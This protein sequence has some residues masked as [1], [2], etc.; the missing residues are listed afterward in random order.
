MADRHR[1]FWLLVFG[2]GVALRLALWSGYGL[3]DDPNYFT[4]YYS[5]YTRGGTFDPHD[6][7]QMR[8]GLWVPV[9]LA[10]RLFGPTEAGFVG[11][12]TICS[13]INLVLIYLLARQEWER[14]Y[15]LL[16]MLLLAVCPL[17]VLCSGLFANDI[18]LATYCFAAL[19]LFRRSLRDEMSPRARFASAAASGMFLF[20]GF[21][22]KPWVILTAPLF[23]IEA[24]ARARRHWR[25]SLVAVGVLAT[26]VGTFLA[27]QW[28]RFGDPLYHVNVARPFAI[29]EPYSRPVLL[30]YPRMLFD[31]NEYGSYFAGYYPHVLVL[32]AALLAGRFFRAGKWLVYAAIMLAGLVALPGGRQNGLWGVIPHIFRYLALL[33]VPLCMALTA[34]WRELFGRR[35]EAAVVWLPAFVILSL[36]QCVA[37]TEPTRDAYGEQRRA[38]AFLRNYPDDPVWMDVSLGGRFVYFELRFTKFERLRSIRGEH[39]EERAREYA[40]ITDGMVVTGGARNPW[41]NCFPCLGYLDHFSVPPTWS[42]EATFPGRPT[43]YR[44]EPLRIWRVS[45]DAVKAKALLDERP[46]WSA[47]RELLTGLLDRGENALAAEVGQHLLADPRTPARGEIALQTGI[48]CLRADELPCA[49]RRL[50]EA[51]ASGLREPQLRDAIVALALLELRR[52]DF[53]KA[54]EWV[55][56]FRR[57]FPESSVDGRLE[58]IESGL[59][60]GLHWYR[61]G[62]LQAARS[63]FGGLARADAKKPDLRRRA[64]YWLALTLFRMGLVDDGRREAVAYR[65]DYGEDESWV[66]IQYRYGEALLARDPESARDVFEELVARDP[67]SSWGREA[68]GRLQELGAAPWDASCSAP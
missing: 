63:V 37:V 17:D 42:L 29:F 60:D 53:V 55:A 26:L 41:Y 14:P 65:D 7:Y 15:A 22:T 30:A 32:L 4:A 40:A 68:D 59:A 49:E 28:R 33:S 50:P 47:R 67:Q 13:I 21:A 52:N 9:V 24:I 27:W 16:A 61:Q 43:R 57:R 51:F 12:I 8:F 31:V 56:E 64:R 62:E 44:P 23:V 46:E 5:I 54:R 25:S 66:E 11:A 36:F 45:A 10:M 1:L 48:A 35:L 18:V 3:G 39:P 19:W 2:L 20:F 38:L 6:P 58:D 34:Y